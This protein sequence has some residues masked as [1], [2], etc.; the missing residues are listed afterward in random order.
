MILENDVVDQIEYAISCYPT[1]SIVC[2]VTSYHVGLNQTVTRIRRNPETTPCPCIWHQS[3]HILF[4]DA[5]ANNGGAAV[6]EDA[7]TFTCAG[8]VSDRDAFDS[9]AVH[10]E[11][12]ASVLSVDHRAGG[13]IAASQDKLFGSH[14]EIL[15]KDPW[16]KEDAVS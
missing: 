7:G 5:I 2:N 8:A 9:A 15:I 6:D 12:A 11:H 3:S 14:I 10:P 13:T 16:P 4:H 1:A